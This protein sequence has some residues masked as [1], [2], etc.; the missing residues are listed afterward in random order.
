MLE[1][2]FFRTINNHIT[3]EVAQLAVEDGADKHRTTRSV[4]YFFLNRFF[5]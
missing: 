5:F 4:G 3:P 1:G 2:S